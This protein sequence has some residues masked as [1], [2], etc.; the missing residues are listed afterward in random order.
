MDLRSCL[1]SFL[2]EL[3]K[4]GASRD[5]LRVLQSRQGR[6]PISVDN[7][8]KKDQ[9][10]TLLKNTPKPKDDEKT[11][12][13]MGRPQDVLA[14]PIDPNAAKTPKKPGD[15][16][17]KEDMDVVDRRDGRDNAV[18]I[19]GEGRT[20]TNVGTDAVHSPSERSY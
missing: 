16:P 7:F 19:P 20:S 11:A 17:S 15:V 1:P 13:A 14:G 9:K 6:R 8:L 4:I 10:G 18:T 2:D 3:E 12:D 5:S